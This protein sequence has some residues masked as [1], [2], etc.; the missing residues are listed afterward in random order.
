[1]VKALENSGVVWISKKLLQSKNV[2]GVIRFRVGNKVRFH[3]E[4]EDMHTTCYECHQEGC[5]IRKSL[6]EDHNM[7]EIKS[8]V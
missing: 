6:N 2:D 8:I 3:E 1:M 5:G 4:E 7:G